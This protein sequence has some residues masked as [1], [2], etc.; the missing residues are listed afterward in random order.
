LPPFFNFFGLYWVPP[1]FLEAC[2]KFARENRE[3][4]LVIMV[5]WGWRWK[6]YEFLFWHGMQVYENAWMQMCENAWV[7]TNIFVFV[8]NAW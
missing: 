4:V 3:T 1:R 8:F 5:E 6:G 2:F 7:C